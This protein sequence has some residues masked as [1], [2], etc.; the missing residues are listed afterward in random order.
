M[1]DDYTETKARRDIG[2]MRDALA[3]KSLESGF[4]ERMEKIADACIQLL[5]SPDLGPETK[6]LAAECARQTISKQ[7]DVWRFVVEQGLNKKP[8]E[9]SETP[10]VVGVTDHN[11][12]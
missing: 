6:L 1:V 5:E 11:Y 4:A 12:S 2:L 8:G 7:V 3:G 10:S 9:N